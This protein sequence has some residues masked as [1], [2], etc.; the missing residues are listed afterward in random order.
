MRESTAEQFLRDVDHH[1]M[2]VMHESGVYRHLRFRQPDTGN[3]W[4]DLVTWPGF[5]TISGDMGTWTF[6]RLPDMFEFFRDSKLRINCDYW[7][8]KLQHGNHIGRPDRPR[9][10]PRA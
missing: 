4:F 10:S 9:S 6:A 8:E 1:N 2:S 5:L 3:M 7:A